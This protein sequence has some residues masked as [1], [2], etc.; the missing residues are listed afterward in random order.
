SYNLTQI[1]ASIT[2]DGCVISA[3]YGFQNDT[4]A[5]NSTGPYIV[6]PNEGFTVYATTGCVWDG[7][8]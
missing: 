2:S 8:V 5:Y 3:I 1:N 7:S 4:Q 6:D